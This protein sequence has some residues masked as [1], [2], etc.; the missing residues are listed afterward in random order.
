MRSPRVVFFSV[1]LILAVLSPAFAQGN[2]GDDAGSVSWGLV[3]L[4]SYTYNLKLN[5]NQRTSLM[6]TLGE[7]YTEGDPGTREEM[8]NLAAQ[9]PRFV[10]LEDDEYE[11]L[12]R[13]VK[14][15]CRGL[16]INRRVIE[17][18]ESAPLPEG[19]EQVDDGEDYVAWNLARAA[20]RG[21]ETSLTLEQI[22]A[23]YS[24]LLDYY[25]NARWDAQTPLKNLADSEYNLHKS[26]ASI[27]AGFPVRCR[28]ALGGLGLE[29]AP[30]QQLP[31]LDEQTAQ[32]MAMAYGNLDI[33]LAGLKK[34]WKGE[35]EHRLED[36][37][38]QI[39]TLIDDYGVE[40]DHPEM[41]RIMALIPQVEAGLEEYE[42]RREALVASAVEPCQQLHEY[43]EIIRGA[44]YQADYGSNEEAV[45]A[46]PRALAILPEAEAFALEFRRIF[47]DIQLLEQLSQEA[48]DAAVSQGLERINNAREELGE[49]M[50]ALFPH[51]LGK[52]E[53]KL[54]QAQENAGDPN[55]MT[56]FA[57]DAIE[58]ANLLL[59][60]DPEHE[61]ATSIIEQAEGILAQAAA[62]FEAQVAENRMPAETRTGG[63]WEAV[64]Q[65]ITAAWARVYPDEPV[66]RIVLTSD[67]IQQAE[68]HFEG[69]LAVIRHYRYMN[70]YVA[71]QQ[72]EEFRVFRSQFRKV[73]GDDDWSELRYY[74]TTGSYQILEENISK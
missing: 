13:N 8:A 11:A 59:E 41:V 34:W 12:Y 60:L 71:A 21:W 50:E 73:W 24:A 56:F 25:Q 44:L 29:V 4:I 74:R 53:E 52:A 19:V 72:G 17:E 66:Q 7:R 9:W 22:N 23:L 43:S 65:T 67:W 40:E 15:F 6:N 62:I 49:A 27:I 3:N 69:N 26:W 5:L 63:D 36:A 10:W 48:R 54:A 28:L 55:M 61:A 51:L 47:P 38:H 35:A 45:E 20:C 68:L 1:V 42:Q 30:I 2:E 37:Q 46:L 31:P 58:Q 70:A 14:R 57:E 33:A 32:K 39:D 18:L 16:K 64:K